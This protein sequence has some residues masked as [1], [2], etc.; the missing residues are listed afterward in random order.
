MAPVPPNDLQVNKP[1]AGWQFRLEM[2]LTNFVLG[3]WKAGAAIL[4]TILLGV[5]IYSVWNSNRVNTM[6]SG[7]AEV[8]EIERVL[9]DDLEAELDPKLQSLGERGWDVGGVY[10]TLQRMP[11]Q[12]QQILFIT[13]PGVQRFAALTQQSGVGA[14]SS[15]DLILTLMDAPSDAAKAKLTDAAQKLEAIAANYSGGAAATAALDAAEHYR[16]AGDKEARRRALMTASAAG[17]GILHATAEL[18][19]AGMELDDPAARD[20]GIAR[21]ETLRKDEDASVAEVATIEVI[22]AYVAA[23][24]KDDAMLAIGDYRVKWPDSERKS[25]VDRLE[26]RAS[27]KAAPAPAEE[28]PLAPEAPTDAPAPAAPE[29]PAP[30]GPAAP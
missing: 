11:Q 14:M 18:A 15:V 30:E 10:T 29:A 1:E 28:N 23:D 3:Y 7:A 21:L 13:S 24:R 16:V 9:R 20:S 2:G 5:L 19:L 4:V 6:K 22:A 25:E 26:Q 27:G 8:A 17:A 12:Q